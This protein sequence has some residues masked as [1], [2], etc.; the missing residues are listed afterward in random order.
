[1]LPSGQENEREVYMEE[2][3]V[4]NWS[5]EEWEGWELEE[6]QEYEQDEDEEDDD[7]DDNNEEEE[8]G[9]GEDVDKKE[10]DMEENMGGASVATDL[11][12]VCLARP[13]N[14][15]TW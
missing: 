10:E 3:E 13:R 7:D 8:E 9:K 14:A 2:G 5:E 11:C 4:E 1:M 12:V 6:D 15:S